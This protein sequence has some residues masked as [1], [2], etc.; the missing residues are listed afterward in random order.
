MSLGLAFINSSLLTLDA[1]VR[2]DSSN[3]IKHIV[4]NPGL[5][6]NNS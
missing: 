1:L 4:L 5:L 2:N 6:L 3:V